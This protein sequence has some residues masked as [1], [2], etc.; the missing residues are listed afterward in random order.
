MAEP[1]YPEVGFAGAA[2][3]APAG[4][5]STGQVTVGT[6]A[7]LI[8]A[9]NPNRARLIV[10]NQ[11]GANNLFLGGVGVTITTGAGTANTAGSQTVFLHRAAVYGVVA[12]S[13]TP[14]SY[15][16]EVL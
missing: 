10:I 7:T 9:D 3:T 16:E 1:G 2:G 14:V 4:S 8:V 6:A 5:F 11:L 12:G 15:I 13:T